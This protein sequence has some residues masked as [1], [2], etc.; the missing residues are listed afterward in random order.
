MGNQTGSFKAQGVQC[1][2]TVCVPQCVY[3]TDRGVPQ[4]DFYQYSDNQY[5]KMLEPIKHNQSDITS[6]PCNLTLC[7][8]QKSTIIETSNKLNVSSSVRLTLY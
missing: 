2:Y 6:K 3:V 4:Y 5:I 7:K 8:L 1:A